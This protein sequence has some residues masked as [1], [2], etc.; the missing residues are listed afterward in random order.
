MQ[1][2]K[3]FTP[4]RTRAPGLTFKT[5]SPVQGMG[6]VDAD[7][8]PPRQAY[9]LG[10]IPFGARTPER[11]ALDSFYLGGLGDAGDGGGDSGADDS[12]FDTYGVS[13]SGS[14]DPYGVSAPAPAPAPAASSSSASWPYF[15]G[16]AP[17]TSSSPSSPSSSSGALDLT[18]IAS[19]VAS[20]FSSGAKIYT[21]AELQQVNA[22]RLAQGLP[23]ISAGA[24]TGTSGTGLS[25][26]TGSPLLLI[27]LVA[28]VL[29]A[30]N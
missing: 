22:Q 9:Y 28:V 21:A 24:L 17:S 15:D 10:V 13:S 26:L 1:T 7:S 18:S 5:S 3:I 25:G 27:G 12:I 19:S 8:I 14:S 23:P 6:R 30:G 2:P 11:A 4:F 16:P 20:L 29:A